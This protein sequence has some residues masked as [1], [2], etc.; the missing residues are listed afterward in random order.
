M[1]AMKT[2]GVLCLNGRRQT[3]K[4]FASTT[5]LEVLQIVCKKQGFIDSEVDLVYQRKALDVSKTIGYLNIPNNGKLEMIRRNVPRKASNINIAI[6]TDY[7]ERITHQFHP[8]TTIFDAL[9]QL[10]GDPGSLHHGKLLCKVPIIIYM[11]NKI[12]G[13]KHLQETTLQSI[14]LIGGNAALRLSHEEEELTTE[15]SAA[16]YDAIAPS[17]EVVT[18]QNNS[19]RASPDSKAPA[20]DMSVREIGTLHD[21]KRERTLPEDFAEPVFK[22]P[23]SDA[24]NNTEVELRTSQD[25][26]TDNDIERA[27]AMSQPFPNFKFPESQVQSIDESTIEAV[28]PK[29]IM[30]AER[31]AMPCN[32]RHCVFD[33]S[34]IDSKVTVKEDPDD[35]FF[36]PTIEDLR[37]RM[38]GL[39]SSS[40]EDAPLLTQSMR[41]A[42]NLEKAFQYKLVV[43]RVQFPGRIVL[44]G[45]FRPLEQVKAVKDFVKEHLT[46]SDEKF[47]LYTAP[48]KCVLKNLDQTLHD[49]KLI[50]TALVHI[51]CSKSAE[52]LLKKDILDSLTIVGEADEIVVDILRRR[53]SQTT[54]STSSISEKDST[55]VLESNIEP[56]LPPTDFKE[57][58]I[59]QPPKGK[60]PKWFRTGKS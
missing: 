57:S 31:L 40:S 19:R 42:K 3:V 21:D 1:A 51:S 46:N 12:R 2:L 55:A 22:R 13:I 35:S 4:I 27:S 32:R 14:G 10:E 48:P 20:K 7:G 34:S 16:Q 49:A 39:R 56:H 59:S 43:I 5:I 52:N 9:K 44:Q 29:K 30:V 11:S 15:E 54:V 36:E 25:M 53:S 28:D 24:D 58:E 38:N 23:K 47:D 50:P 17:S 8:S 41:A 26:I 37:L 45:V 6:Q 60:I 18:D 33:L